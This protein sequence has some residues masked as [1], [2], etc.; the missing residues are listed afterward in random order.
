MMNDLMMN[1]VRFMAMGIRAQGASGV[2]LIMDGSMNHSMSMVIHMT[3]MT[4][5]RTPIHMGG[6]RRTTCNG[7]LTWGCS[8]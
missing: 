8:P 1:G 5:M 4:M 7:R 6:D 3:M 2:N